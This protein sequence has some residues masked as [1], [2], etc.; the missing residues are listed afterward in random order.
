MKKSV[1]IIDLSCVEPNPFHYLSDAIAYIAEVTVDMS[2]CL[3]HDY[4]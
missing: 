4:V 3:H 2:Q 1:Y